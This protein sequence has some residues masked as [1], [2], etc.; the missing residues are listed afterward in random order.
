MAVPSF[1]EGMRLVRAKHTIIFFLLLVNLQSCL[2][3]FMQTKGISAVFLKKRELMQT[4]SW[5]SKPLPVDKALKNISKYDAIWGAQILAQH[6]RP[7]WQYLRQNR[8]DH[9]ML[10]SLSSSTIRK[11]DEIL[12]PDPDYINKYHPEWFL[13]KDARNT[14]L[15]DYKDV[16]KR[17]RW[18]PSDPS[19][20]YYNR[21][22][23]DVVNKDFQQWA[24]KEILAHVSGEKQEL[25]FSYDGVAFDNVYVSKRLHQRFRYKY[26]HWKYA[27]DFKAWHKGFADY[28]KVVKKLLNEHGF[29]LV[30]NH[31]PVGSDRSENEQVW[32]MLY[33]GVDGILTERALRSGWRNKDYF[34]GDE[35]LA[36]ITRHEEILNKGLINW[37]V[38]SP[39]KDGKLDRES[40]LYTYCSWLLVKQSDKSYYSLI[41][42]SKDN[43]VPWY[44]EYNL[45]IGE[46]LGKRY[47][48]DNCW[49]RDYKNAAII[50]V[51][52]TRQSQQINFCNNG[53]IFVD[54]ATNKM[55][56]GPIFM[57]AQSGRIFL[58]TTDGGS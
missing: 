38:C 8:P 3:A 34:T 53:E 51:N 57:P 6:N 12:R 27:N 20:T 30:A 28:L 2:L 40:F 54:H 35:W 11:D 46:P 15:E 26:P 31:N 48:Q 19:H 43:A 56:S 16:N 29:I 4:D 1:F 24:A 9:I 17:I 10:Y 44:E 49:L 58:R 37:W 47:R 25:A 39:F 52:P 50:V 45:P 23:L 7:A 5:R 55:F 36:A 22:Y 42:S 13:L 18:L 32:Q 41:T 21:F 33:D 14:T